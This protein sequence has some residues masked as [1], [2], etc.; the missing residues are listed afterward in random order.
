MG[1]AGKISRIL[2]PLF[3]GIFTYA[4]VSKGRESAPGQ[5]TIT[6]LREIYALLGVD[7]I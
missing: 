2:S 3:G 6:E 1:Q 5:L 7:L 4:S